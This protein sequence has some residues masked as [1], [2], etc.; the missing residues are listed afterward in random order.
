MKR[1]RK[2][3]WNI[4]ARCNQNCLYCHRFL[5]VREL[6]YEE[7]K[8][9][10]DNL[11]RDGVTHI[12]WTGGEALL[13]PDLYKLI[14]FSKENG[15]YNR[16]ITNGKLL[17]DNY[18]V[19]NYLS[20]LTIS[21]DS[22]RSQTNLKLGRGEKHFENIKNI[23]DYIQNGKYK[24]L[25]VNVNTVVNKQNINEIKELG[26]FLNQYKIGIW[27]LYNFIPLR[28]TAQK[29]RQLFEITESE[30]DN[31][32]QEVYEKYENINNIVSKKQKELEKDVLIIADGSI[33]KT[34]KGI[35][36]LLGNALTNNVIKY[37]NE[38][39][40]V[41]GDDLMNKIK[42]LIAYDDEETQNKIYNILKDI[43][44][45]EIVA[46]T[47]NPEDTYKKIIEF[48]PEMV[49]SKYDFGTD[50][51]GLD[52]IKK[53]KEVLKE[54]VPAFNFIALNIPQEDFLEAKRMIGDKMNTVIREHNPVR[55]TGIIQDYKEYINSKF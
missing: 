15:V 37:I 4:T 47:K 53:S 46:R 51:N 49:F 16:V 20:D 36:F 22:I 23:L 30:F 52:I 7:N 38:D 19:L 3:C 44:D 14:K 5:N 43:S 50:M 29:N 39:I 6:N 25:K 17:V 1:K 27:K 54:D 12:T 28:E 2:V 21:L 35:D 33:I 32:F 24:K 41:I 34:E 9:I 18:D 11:I 8:Q 31:A 40:N 48:K 10:L 55:Y 42:T 26:E 13:Y 45:V